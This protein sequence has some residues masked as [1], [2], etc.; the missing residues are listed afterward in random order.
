MDTKTVLLIILAAIVSIAVVL[1]QYFYGNKRSGRFRIALSFLRFVAIFSGLLLL[2]NPKF[3]KNNFYVEK[4]KLLVLVDNSSS[5]GEADKAEKVQQHARELANNSTI[6]GRF[7][8]FQYGFDTDFR[9]LDSLTLSGKGTNINR[10]LQKAVELNGN[11]DAVAVLFSDGNQTVGNDYQFFKTPISMQLN[12]VVLGDTT[13]YQDLA[14]RRVTLNKYAFLGNRFPIEATINYQG[15]QSISTSVRVL[16]NGTQVHR[17]NLTFSKNQN[18]KTVSALVTAQSVGVKSVEVTVGQLQNERNTAN[19]SKET[20]IEVIDEK[21]RIALIS[22]FLHPDIGALKKSIEANEQRSVAIVNP[23]LDTNF[24]DDIDVAILYQPTSSFDK[25]YQEIQARAISTITIT[26]TKTDLN[27]VNRKNENRFSLETGYPEQE[28]FGVTNQVFPHF[29][30]SGFDSNGFPPLLS[31]A[32]PLT[33]V[34][35]ADVLMNMKIKGAVM[36]SPLMAI[37]NG[38]QTKNVVLFGENIWQWR[39]Q[40]FR[41]QGNFEQ[42]DNFMGKLLVYLSQSGKRERLQLDYE[43]VYEGVGRARIRASFFDKTYVLDDSANLVLRVKNE[44][45]GAL[46]E[47]PML[48]KSGYHEA[49]LENL[50]DGSYSFTVTETKENISKS[51]TFKILEFD[52]E[53]QLYSSDHERLFRLAENNG[54]SVYHPNEIDTLLQDLQTGDRYVPI[55]KNRQ[56]VVS[57]IDFKVL[58]GLMALALATEWLIRKYNG[59]L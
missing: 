12:T 42:F 2:I 56:K 29:D 49:V 15:N 10:A 6:N 46:N 8:V 59:L 53:K 23:R 24:F 58:L 57:L 36:E 52:A 31:D 34:S 1:F 25:A 7:D 4:L 33:F 13:K 17:E 48:Y 39:A 54:G 22:D 5:M 14:V 19:N 26:G 27:F 16:L 38:Q 37:W 30:I 43:K 55:Q 3:V 41:D 20:A 45:T 50:P 18:G 44:E 51:G 35:E 28:V 21:S 9:P 47:I 32:G 11:S 40:S